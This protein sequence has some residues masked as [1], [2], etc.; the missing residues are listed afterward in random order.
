MAHN[1]T[2]IMT[3]LILYHSNS[4]IVTFFNGVDYYDINNFSCHIDASILTEFFCQYSKVLI[5]YLC[6]LY[7][8]MTCTFY[9]FRTLSVQLT[10]HDFIAYAQM[11]N[12]ENEVWHDSL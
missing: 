5:F 2:V 9:G 1:I 8:E 6:I 4:T 3:K 10:L 12:Y 7:D 11:Y